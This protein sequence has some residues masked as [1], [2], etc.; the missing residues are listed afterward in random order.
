ML[1]VHMCTAQPH[2]SSACTQVVWLSV[3]VRMCAALQGGA[4]AASGLFRAKSRQLEQ[5]SRAV[6]VVKPEEGA[7]DLFKNTHQKYG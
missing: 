4:A 1:H 2:P 6:V 7:A 5:Q 3:G